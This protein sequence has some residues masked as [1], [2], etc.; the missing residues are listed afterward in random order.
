MDV[1]IRSLLSSMVDLIPGDRKVQNAHCRNMDPVIPAV[2][3]TCCE[4]TNKQTHK[5]NTKKQI[6]AK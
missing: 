5:K 1:P 6:G 4:K 3:K 2:L